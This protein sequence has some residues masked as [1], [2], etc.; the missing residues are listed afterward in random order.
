M[1]VAK[2]FSI[3]LAFALAI[4]AQPPVREWANAEEYD[5]GSQALAAP[6]PKQRI[7]LLRD[8]VAR[9]PKST[10]ERER[11]ISF[12]KAFQQTGDPKESLKRATEALALNAND[13]SILLLIAA[14]GPT[15]PAASGSEIATVAACAVKLLSISFSR[16]P[17]A[18]TAPQAE[19]VNGSISFMDPETQ[20]VLDFI[21]RIRMA[22]GPVVEKDPE[23]I[24]KLAEAALQWAKTTKP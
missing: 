14:L 2:V 8:W 3:S 23:L 21:R 24:R 17:E 1:A 4:G 22:R 6:D 12:A 7:T 11:L 15:L 19:P 13:P 9:Y 10:F 18:V 5:L 16:K 20:R